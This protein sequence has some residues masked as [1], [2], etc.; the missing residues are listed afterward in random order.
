MA[1]PETQ[2]ALHEASVG[3]IASL[4]SRA[5]PIDRGD[6]LRVGDASIRV[7]S[8]GSK[9]AEVTRL[10]RGRV[11]AVNDGVRCRRFPPDREGRR[12]RRALR[13]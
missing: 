1:F 7:G 6:G 5:L 12:V 13:Q 3:A 9:V 11:G 2:I 4:A 8:A 10:R